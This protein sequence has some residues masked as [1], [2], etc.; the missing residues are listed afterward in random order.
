[1]SWN[2][3]TV[4]FGVPI[5]VLSY[6]SG[7]WGNGTPVLNPTSTGFFGNGEVHGVIR[8]PGTYSSVTFTHTTENWHGFTVGAIGQGNGNAVPEPGSVALIS[9]ALFTLGATLRRRRS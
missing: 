2:G 1:M 6:G 8:L 7:Y 4:D 9:L 5:E 3:N